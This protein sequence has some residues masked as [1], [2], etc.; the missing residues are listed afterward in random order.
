M[1][2]IFLS[3]VRRTER[4]ARECTYT[5]FLKCQPLNFK[6][7]EGVVGLSQWFKRM[8]SVFHISNCTVENQVK[9]AT[10]TLHSIALT[11]GKKH[12]MKFEGTSMNTHNQQQQQNKRQNIGRAY[13]AWTGEKDYNMGDLNPYAQNATI[14]TM[15]HVLLNATNA[16]KLAILPVTVG[17]RKMPIMLITRRALGQ[18]RSLLAMSVEFKDILRGNVQS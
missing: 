4:T 15:V 16:T 1:I 9:F 12:L 13:T 17:V 8:E 11:W 3:G 18:V 2:A 10:C 5:D 14:T 7:T 6:G